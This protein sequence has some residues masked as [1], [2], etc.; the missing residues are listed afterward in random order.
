MRKNPTFA[1]QK[2]WQYFRGTPPFRRGGGLKVW[3]QKPIADF[4]VDF[5]CPKLNLVMEVDGA[6]RF[7]PKGIDDDKA[8]TKILEAYLWVLKI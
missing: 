1:E 4:I 8:R 7:T 5:Y 6:S 3:L 2:L